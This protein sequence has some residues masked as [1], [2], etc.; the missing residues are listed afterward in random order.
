M[1]RMSHR[2]AM[3][4]AT[5]LLAAAPAPAQTGADRGADSV[6]AFHPGEGAGY[7]ATYFPSNVLG[8]PDTTGREEVPAIDP[9][10]V[11]GLGLGGEIVLRFAR[12]PIVDGPGPDFTIFENPFYYTIGASRRLYAEPGEVSVSRDGVT[13][14]PFPFDSTTLHGCA[15]VTPTNGDRNPADPTVSGGDGF[16]LHDLGIDTVRYVRIRDV[17]PMIRNNTA[18]PFWD[19]TLNGFDLDA[20]VCLNG[21]GF[22]TAAGIDEPGRGEAVSAVE[23]AP[24]PIRSAGTVRVATAHAGHLR[25]TLASPL[26]EHV[27]L[28]ADEM[29]EAGTHRYALAAGD[30]PSGVYL[31]IVEEDGSPRGAG[32][33]VIAR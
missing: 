31:V 21:V 6:V 16:D 10:Q 24:N 9:R 15:G 22:E 30:L 28:L 29:V 33:V 25:V 12:H 3:L 1:M 13:F 2:I 17:T 19:P 20:V 23:V 5:V 26:G 27:R 14:I 18:S 32:R 8:L 11:L 4:A 7:G